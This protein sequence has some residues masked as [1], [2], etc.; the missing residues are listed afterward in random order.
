MI[1][2]LAPDAAS[3]EAMCEPINP[4]P[5]VTSAIPVKAISINE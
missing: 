5:P 2:T 1:L 4:A 3:A